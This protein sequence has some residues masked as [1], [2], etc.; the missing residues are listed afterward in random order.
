[1][2]KFPFPLNRNNILLFLALWLMLAFPLGLYTLLIGPS[3]WLAA[4]AFQHR[5]SEHL[6]ENLQ[7]GVIVLWFIVSLTL[8]LLVTRL[9]LKKKGTYRPIV[10]GFLLA[11][12]GG[13]VYLFSFH[14]E[15][16]IKW[17]GSSM[18]QENQKA[19]GAFGNEIEFT[20]GSYP[21]IDKIVQLK[22][23]G[24]T[25]I[26][27]LMSELVVPAEPKLLHEEKEHT[28][29][30]GIQLIHIPMLPWV[31]G[32]EK[33]MERIRQ[34]IKTG[35][36]K[37][38]VH[39]YLGRDRVNIFRKMV[40][41]NSTNIQLRA[42]T[43]IRKIE[44]LPRF[45][46]GNYFKIGEKVYLTPFPTDEEFIG[47]IVNGNFKAVISLLDETDPADKP[48]TVREKKI[49]QAYNVRYINLPYKN[50]TDTKTLQKIIDSISHLPSPIIIH[51]F[52]SDDPTIS[53]IKIALGK[54]K[55]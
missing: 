9:F 30:V 20:I 50:T 32:N 35:H 43:T 44:D 13:S 24:Y 29:K 51:G 46:R 26:I 12:F 22:D 7:K 15:I 39:C 16:Y 45:E 33:A 10:F 54:T 42:T 36:G 31:S 52:R 18:V 4:A 11:L 2:I 25:A 38:Y 17:S 41:D 6:S 40:T 34:L 49:L 19:S 1:M 21:D 3:K 5:W 27:T 47:Y 28:A 48:W 53:R 55:L 14:P 8:A 37:Y 23:E